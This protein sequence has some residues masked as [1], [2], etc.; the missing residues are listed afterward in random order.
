MGEVT[1]GPIVDV[2]DG[3]GLVTRRRQVLVDGVPVGTVSAVGQTDTPDGRW[4][5]F[6][7]EGWGAEDVDGNRLWDIN[8]TTQS[9]AVDALVRHATR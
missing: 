7:S 2:P 3:D 5:L 6:A 8:H 1:R 4:R 9:G